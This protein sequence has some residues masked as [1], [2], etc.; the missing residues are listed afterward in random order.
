[1]GVSVS[2]PR[3][4][5]PVRPPDLMHSEWRCDN[6]GPVPP[7]HVAEHIGADI[8][9]SATERVADTGQL[10][11]GPRMPFWCPWPLLPGWTMTGIAWAGDDRTGVRATAVACSGPAPLGDG[12]A[13]LLLVAEE[14]GVGL[15][16]RLA[17]IEGPDPG[18]SLAEAMGWPDAGRAGHPPHAKVKA[19]GH[20]TPLWMVGSAA[21]RSTYVGE[22]RGMWLYA[23]G[24]PADA[25]YLLAEDLVLL[26]LVEWLPPELV[27]GA[28]SPRLPGRPDR[29]GD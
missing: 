13:D 9:A 21:D 20:P 26:D 15:G 2:C 25:G 27:F 29:L 11:H 19:A 7:L 5:G 28:P 24:W 23:I 22:A 1:V 8:V 4:G 12:P 6:C 17:G 10:D 3:C 16:T 14:P 18:R